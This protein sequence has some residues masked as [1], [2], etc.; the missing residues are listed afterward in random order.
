MASCYNIGVIFGCSPFTREIN[1]DIVSTLW[2]RLKGRDMQCIYQYDSR[3][4]ATLSLDVSN[5]YV[6]FFLV[7]YLFAKHCTS[8]H[9]SVIIG[10]RTG[11]I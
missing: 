3:I 10:Y 6:N 11:V 8:A 5:F 7:N 4:V 2:Q 1:A 9:F